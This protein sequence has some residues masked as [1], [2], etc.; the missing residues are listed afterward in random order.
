MLLFIWLLTL[1]IFLLCVLLITIAL[2][3]PLMVLLFL[4]LDGAHFVL[5]LFM[6][7]VF[8]LF[9]IW[10]YSLCL[11]GRLLTMIIVSFLTLIFVIF[12]IVARVI[13]LVLAPDTVTHRV[14]V[15]LALSSFHCACSLTSPAVA[16]PSTSSFFQW[17]HRLGHLCGSWLSALL[18]RGL[19]GSVSGWESLDHC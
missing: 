2:F 7:L 12:R 14:R 9:L 13:C 8:L 10:P 11:L 1:L 3:I 15:W 4:L 19:L 18:R 5:T 6:S 16:A 17:H